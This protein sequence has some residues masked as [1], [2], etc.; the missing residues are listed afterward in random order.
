M[1]LRLLIISWLWQLDKKKWSLFCVIRSKSGCYTYFWELP[2]QNRAEEYHNSTKKVI[3]NYPYKHFCRAF[4]VGWYLTLK[5]YFLLAPVFQVYI[6]TEIQNAHLTEN[7]MQRDSMQFSGFSDNS[8][9]RFYV[10]AYDRHFKSWLLNW[11]G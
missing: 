2:D 7:E 1:E 3:I 8:Q 10:E 11:R 4:L 5:T 9:R 6:Q